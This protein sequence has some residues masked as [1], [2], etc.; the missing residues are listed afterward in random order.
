MRDNKEKR[1]ENIEKREMG[2]ESECENEKPK[3]EE[4]RNSKK[5]RFF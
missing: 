2:E 4:M 1:W 5:K 3:R